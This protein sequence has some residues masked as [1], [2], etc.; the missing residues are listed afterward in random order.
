MFIYPVFAASAFLTGGVVM[1]T[2][3]ED[4]QVVEPTYISSFGEIQARS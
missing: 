3:V 4:E 2:R 1:K